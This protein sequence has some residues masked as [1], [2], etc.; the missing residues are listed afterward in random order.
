MI[1]K[2]DK[3]KYRSRL[4]VLASAVAMAVAGLTLAAPPAL[5]HE[6]SQLPSICGDSS[7]F[8]VSDSGGIGG[9][10][11]RSVETVAGDR[12]G[13]VYLLYSNSLGKNCV[14]TRKTSYHGTS[15]TTVAALGVQDVGEV[16]DPPS[17]SNAK[18]SH[19]AA[20]QRSAGGRC[21]AYV[22]WIRNPSDNTQ[23]W[24]GRLA[25][26]NCG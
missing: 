14:V 17:G 19:F 26:A 21:V 3:M 23:A 24:G 10:A 15:T 2:R 8:I 5:A 22:G 9:K 4:A 11:K 16:R 7:Y 20:V 1:T 13:Y 6:E 25:H 12:W 18:Y